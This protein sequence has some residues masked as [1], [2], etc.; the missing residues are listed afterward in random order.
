MKNELIN[1]LYKYLSGNPNVY[2]E[3]TENGYNTIY[4]PF[5]ENTIKRM[6]D[7]KQSFLTYQFIGENVK[8]ICFDF[9]I[10]K[11]TTETSDYKNKKQEY[12]SNL[13]KT[14]KVFCE[15]LDLL[16]ITYLAEFSGNR[17]F[18]IWVV[19][20]KPVTGY[21]ARQILL[22]IKN[23][24]NLQLNKDIFGL[25]EFPKKSS[26][27]GKIG[28][29][30]KLPL[31]LHKKSNSYSFLF[32]IQKVDEQF[33]FSINIISDKL[34]KEQLE[35]L[36]SFKPLNVKNV[37]GKFKINIEQEQ[38]EEAPKYVKSRKPALKEKA[39]INQILADL[40]KCNIINPIVE[41][42]EKI[43]ETK[44]G[45]LNEKERAFLV[46]L[47]NRLQIESDKSYGKKILKDFFSKLPNYREKLTE[48]KLDNLNFYP[49]TC[50]YLKTTEPK[51]EC[52]CKFKKNEEIYK[53]PIELIE[54]ID[55]DTL[56]EDIFEILDDDL[57]KI[58]NSQ[59]N[60]I[61]YNDEIDLTFQFEE[62]NQ[63]NIKEFISKYL[64][65]IDN[66]KSI[67]KY[68]EYKRIED[69]DK[70]RNLVSLSVFDKLLTTA[71]TKVLD[72][73]HF[74]ERSDNSYGY[75]F[76]NSFT[77]YQ[78]FEPWLKQW[79]IYIKGLDNIIFNSD[80]KD[81]YI[82]KLDLKSFYSEIDL[83]RLKIK[84]L[85]GANKSIK[86]KIEELDYISKKRYYNVCNTLISFCYSIADKGVPQG[87]AFARY[88][89]E[90]YLM[91][92][93]EFIEKQLMVGER[94]FR[95]VDDIFI[96]L[97][98]DEKTSKKILDNFTSFINTHNLSINHKNE[99]YFFGNILDYQDEFSNY[100]DKTKYFI[101]SSYKN[102]QI[103]STTGT[104]HAIKDMFSLID[105]KQNNKIKNENLNFF[106][107]HF[108][109]SLL[110]HEKKKELEKYVLNS[111]IG[112]GSLFRNFYN[113]YFEQLK[114]EKTIL[115]DEIYNLSGLN[116]GVF[117]NKLLKF[118]SENKL[119]DNLY[120][121]LDKIIK[122]FFT[123]SL[124]DYEIEILIHIMFKNNKLLNKKYFN[125][126]NLPIIQKVI[127]TNTEKKVPNEIIVYL[128]DNLQHIE[129]SEKISLIF[130]IIFN[131]KIENKIFINLRDLFF[132]TVLEDIGSSEPETY[133][134]TVFK[135][136]KKKDQIEKIYQYYQLL[137]L[138]SITKSQ[139]PK[140]QL[141]NLKHLW[142]NF[143]SYTNDIEIKFV[144]HQLNWV[145][146][147]AKI[148]LNENI[149][150]AIIASKPDDTFIDNKKD[151]SKLFANF[152]NGVIYS[153]YFKAQNTKNIDLNKLLSK[154]AKEAIKELIEKEN[155]I[156][157]KWLQ[158]KRTR[159]YPNKEI[160]LQN[161][162]E[163]ERL[164]LKRDNEILVRIKTII[165]KNET[166]PNTDYSY[167]K[168]EEILEK[169]EHFKSVIYKLPAT[170][171]SIINIIKQKDNLIEVI[172]SILSIKKS[173]YEFKVNYHPEISFFPNIIN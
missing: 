121:K 71:Y 80:F 2:A 133:K 126:N 114:E 64:Y 69:D 134:L 27:N 104:K 123:I 154:E 53:T 118:I 75:K 61:K 8:W 82:I 89:A 17:G 170:Y 54:N 13:L 108:D 49:L 155:L 158:D 99:K 167:I 119:T 34:E 169:N 96:F 44:E 146:Q 113:F 3:Q 28:Y 4:K 40:K 79:N 56:N 26:R 124:N 168:V 142:T 105:D 10:L 92:I 95:Y 52:P 145:K 77:N 110:V 12:H 143:M 91:Q 156:F 149:A 116:R 6:I 140:H 138:F 78:L 74:T 164:V 32:D 41:K 139:T 15:K 172:E 63:L 130:R 129:L 42:Y 46:G 62:L 23:E 152:Y 60:Y 35:I 76:S 166:R 163:N 136:V 111:L 30:V 66:P 98:R 165:N 45:S 20:E 106:F 5:T 24:T 87:P 11:E 50:N 115:H 65:Y 1:I 112:R 33:D 128:L 132:N 85:K 14:V 147:I 102:N 48:K 22:K 131:N 47:L 100:K 94:Y 103:I 107:T 25:D 88:L 39:T 101:D 171:K 36:N 67:D 68:Y 137:C 109:K 86:E 160:C 55:I 122:Y 31:S 58:I 161:I 162:I 84:L 157:L 16:K 148:E 70:E 18:H 7:E 19:F 144:N 51:I 90:I 141:E 57:M 29:G 43:V 135:N 93:D 173:I 81:Y 9:D 120:E 150:N 21:I 97:N 38:K 127:E 73:I 125:K 37:I 59:I 151:K 159:L 72:S 117:L 153:V 83:N